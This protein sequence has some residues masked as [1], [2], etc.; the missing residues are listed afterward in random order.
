MVCQAPMFGPVALAAAETQ[1]AESFFFYTAL[2]FPST[3]GTVGKHKVSIAFAETSSGQLA[4]SHLLNHL[5]GSPRE[6]LRLLLKESEQGRSSFNVS[7]E[8]VSWR[9]PKSILKACLVLIAK[10]AVTS[11]LRPLRVTTRQSKQRR[12]QA[13]LP[14][15]LA[16]GRQCDA[17]RNP[18]LLIPRLPPHAPEASPRAWPPSAP[19]E[20][21]A[22]AT[23]P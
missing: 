22:Q 4:E 18:G 6:D 5:D 2:P 13:C 10:S 11:H 17:P 1:R 12:P 19:G 16:P 21:R 20:Q 14:S 3:A 8:A 9:C 7:A 15:R 23:G